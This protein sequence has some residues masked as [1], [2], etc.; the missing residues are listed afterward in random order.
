MK[1]SLL[2]HKHLIIR[3]EVNNPPKE[4]E[5]LTQ[6]LKDLIVFIDMKI[7]MGPYVKYCNM[8]GNRGITGIAVIE[9]SHIAIHVWDEP[10]PAMIQLDVYS[11]AEFDPYT[12]AEKIKQDFDVVKLDYK[13][14]NRETGLKPIRTKKQNMF[15]V[16]AKY[17]EQDL[18]NINKEE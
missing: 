18:I 6:W 2:V 1:N 4:E 11:C 14:L 3:A 16:Q 12:I 15:S 13:F 17:S 5:Y 7:L 10:V 8:E 9:T